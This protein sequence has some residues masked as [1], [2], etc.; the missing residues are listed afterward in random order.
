[1]CDDDI[2]KRDLSE[3]VSSRNTVQTL[4]DEDLF[5]DNRNNFSFLCILNTEFTNESFV[6]FVF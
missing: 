5:Q 3:M 1:M 4:F 2:S 6:I